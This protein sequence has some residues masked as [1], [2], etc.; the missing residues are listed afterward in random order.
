MVSPA[1]G[2]VNCSSADSTAGRL[3]VCTVPAFPPWM[4]ERILSALHPARTAVRANAAII[5]FKAL[6]NGPPCPYV[7]A[8]MAFQKLSL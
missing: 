7:I 3:T 5:F 4:L 8:T 6:I 2:W 1:A